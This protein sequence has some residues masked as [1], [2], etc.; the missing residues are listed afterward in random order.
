MASN[1]ISSPFLVLPDEVPNP[2][3]TPK[4]QLGQR[5]YWKALSNPDFGHILGVVW[6]TEASVKAIGYHYAVLL[7]PTSPSSTFTQL[8]W[9][10]EDDLAAMPVHPPFV[11]YLELIH[12][13]QV[14]VSYG[15][16]SL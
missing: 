5:V 11:F 13:L 6:A 4:F 7:D 10:F 14:D 16:P 1:A 15:N 9:A 12:P 3:P 2:L 8:D